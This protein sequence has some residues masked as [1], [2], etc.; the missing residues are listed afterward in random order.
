MVIRYASGE[1]V[2]QTESVH[3]GAAS[4]ATRRA[5]LSTFARKRAE[6]KSRHLAHGKISTESP[7]LRLVKE[8]AIKSDVLIE[9]FK[10]GSMSGFQV[11]TRLL[12]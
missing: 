4:L 2:M 1:S 6:S 10:P 5:L 3:G 7:S 9:N 8:L 12:C 11:H